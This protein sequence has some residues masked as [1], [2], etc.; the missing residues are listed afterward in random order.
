MDIETSAEAWEVLSG[1]L[2][3][4][5]VAVVW[6]EG[7]GC[8]RA[9]FDTILELKGDAIVSRTYQQGKIVRE[10]GHTTPGKLCWVDT[11]TRE[12]A[13]VAHWPFLDTMLDCLQ[14]Q[15]GILT[16]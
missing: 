6:H 1:L 15:Q 12:R 14:T 7:R 11:W 16:T 10:G 4:G 3:H 13:Q 5:P 9:D 2:D 8:V